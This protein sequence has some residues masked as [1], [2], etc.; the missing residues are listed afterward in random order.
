MQTNTSSSGT[1]I[2]SSG[3][4]EILPR[5]D[6]FRHFANLSKSESSESLCPCP[7]MWAAQ[8]KTLGSYDG[9]L[10]GVVEDGAV[11]MF[12]TTWRPPKKTVINDTRGQRGRGEKGKER[13]EAGKRAE[14]VIAERDLS[15][16]VVRGLRRASPR[17]ACLLL[18]TGHAWVVRRGRRGEHSR[19]HWRCC[20]RRLPG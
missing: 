1:A 8:E 3:L 6:P 19:G 7:W 18:R 14:T 5:L 16:S 10:A 11:R 20:T 13:G 15:Q 4:M 12:F 17:I 9:G 2:I